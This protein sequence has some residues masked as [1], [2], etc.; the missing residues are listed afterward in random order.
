[1]A[2]LEHVLLCIFIL[3]QVFH[4]FVWIKLSSP[5]NWVSQSSLSLSFSFFHVTVLLFSPLTPLMVDVACYMTLDPLETLSVLADCSDVMHWISDKL[6]GASEGKSTAGIWLPHYSTHL[7]SWGVFFFY[8]SLQRYTWS[9]ILWS[10]MIKFCWY[11][12]LC[13]QSEWPQCLSL[14]NDAYWIFGQR[15]TCWADNVILVLFICNYSIY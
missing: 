6:C 14:L 9:L 2:C 5:A 12:L 11:L 3:L 15:K 1:M 10:V 4:H 8:R 7:I 13:Q